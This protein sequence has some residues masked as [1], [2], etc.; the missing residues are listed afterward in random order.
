M[1]RRRVEIFD[2][3]RFITGQDLGQSRLRFAPG[4]MIYSQGARADAAYYV[5]NGYVK[6]TVVTSTGKEAV[7]GLRG[8][9]Q[10]FGTRCLIGRRM[11]AATAA[12]A[13]SLVRITTSALVR[14]LQEQPAFAVM[15][16]T[17]LVRQSVNDQANLIDQL[18]YPAEMRLARMLWRLAND[19]GIK[20]S[21]V[22]P[23]PLNQVV[24]ANMIGTTRSRVSFF[25]NK[26]KRLGLIDYHRNGSVEVHE[27]L[28]RA[29][30]GR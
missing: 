21:G 19:D 6:I 8:E 14:L 22:I 3:G 20:G 16:V 28:S 2:P 10:F 26:F 23:A 11:G 24:L 30:D 18:T 13:C 15:F 7:V 5:D 29:L 1:A 4:H 9:G 25:M 17:Y 27:S 12:A